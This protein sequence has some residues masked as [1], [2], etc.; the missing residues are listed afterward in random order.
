[1]LTSLTI[2]NYALIDNL[3]VNFES[4]LTTITGETGAGKSILLG[5]LSLILGK[6]AD[7]SVAKDATKKSIVEA[8]FNVSNYNLKSL[9]LDNELD[10]DTELIVRRELLP[11]GK[12]RA[13]INDEVVNLSTLSIFGENLIDIHS[14]HQT[15]S[16]I[17]DSYQFQ[18]IDVLAKN[19][20]N[21]KAYS[22]NLKLYKQLKGELTQ[23]QKSKADAAKEHDYNTFLLNE[24]REA[25]LEM[26]Q[27]SELELEYET[28]NNV[29]DV[30]YE[31]QTSSQ[32]ITD[33]QLGVFTTLGL[34]KN[35]IQKLSE[36]A[37]TYT[38]L[39]ERVTSLSIEM[40]DIAAEIDNF[41]ELLEANPE[42][43]MVVNNQLQTLQNLFQK[44]AVSQIEQL[45]EIQNELEQKVGFSNNID[46][47]I[48]EKQKA[49]DAIE[50]RVDA[51]A[52]IINENRNLV[53][54]KLTKQLES[55]LVDLGMPN[56]SFDISLQLGTT[57]L[58][59]GKDTLSF[60]FSANKG[61]NY[62]P[63]K[64]AVSGGELSRIMLAIKYILSQHTHLP[65]IMFDEIDT[66]VSG[67]ISNKMASI[68]KQMS[69]AMQV[70]SITHLPQIAAKGNTHF[71]V[72]KTDD[73]E[74]TTSNLVRLNK[75]QR[76]N[77]IA[78]M[79]DGK[80]ASQSAIAHAKQLLSNE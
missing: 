20:N 43:L 38:P 45:I 34:L 22:A 17:D 36:I 3:H 61:A 32:L 16:L 56:A 75:T 19:S 5:G 44:H 31:L 67:E 54:P 60:L 47:L 80:N 41:N 6:R 77:E 2:K 71:K 28:L 40:D 72:F 29:E 49:Y 18:I 68:M 12:S 63:L 9:F 79:L 11:S 50:K 39:L 1:M 62:K 26:V 70:F 13:F 10:Y 58:E 69:T 35:S 48:V 66:G 24:L 76:V 15:L 7:L 25:K 37:H 42:R 33:E 57:F 23:L 73:N 59:N 30:K 55:V 46:D 65:T 51:N 64:K 53:L 4:G 8:V 27:M 74:I 21:L 52:K 78:Q 14:Q